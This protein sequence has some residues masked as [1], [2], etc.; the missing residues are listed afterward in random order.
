MNSPL[1]REEIASSKDIIKKL[2]VMIINLTTK[3]VITTKVVNG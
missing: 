2:V 3:V 1:R